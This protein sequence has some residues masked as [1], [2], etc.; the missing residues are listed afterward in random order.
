MKTLLTFLLAIIIF[1]S[2]GESTASTSEPETV[3][4]ESETP[5]EAEPEMSKTNWTYRTDEDKMDGSKKHYAYVESSNQVEFDFPYNGG[6]SFILI[7][8]NAG[9][10]DEVIFKVDKGQFSG[11]YSDPNLRVKFDK[12]EPVN[13]SYSESSD[14]SSDLV[15]ISNEKKFIN[16]LLRAQQLMIEAVYF[17]HGKA[18]A[19]FDVAGLEWPKKE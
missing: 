10:G 17:D 11:S 13:F 7:V 16:K 9:Q 2:C 6:S 3:E 8:R 1:S 5:K 4:V 15:F 12:E 18:I 14:G 19:E